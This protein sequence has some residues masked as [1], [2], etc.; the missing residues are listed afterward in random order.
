MHY[1]FNLTRP[2]L[3]SARRRGLREPT[4]FTTRGEA[5]VKPLDWRLHRQAHYTTEPPSSSN[6]PQT[7]DL[8]HTYRGLVALGKIKYDEE[9]VRVVMQ[10]D[11]RSSSV[12]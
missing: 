4:P 7:I 12:V 5:R 2:I 8:L 1:P 11:T 9:Q 10:V 6:L 3:G